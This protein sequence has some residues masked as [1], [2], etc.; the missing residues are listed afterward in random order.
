MLQPGPGF[1]DEIGQM[2][3]EYALLLALIAVMTIGALLM[4]GGPHP[5]FF[6]RI[7]SMIGQ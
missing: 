2:V 6:S 3:T 4:V 7:G 5:G 1:R